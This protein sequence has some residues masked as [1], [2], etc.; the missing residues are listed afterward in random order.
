[1]IIK[2]KDKFILENA[3]NTSAT[4]IARQHPKYLYHH[5]RE[6]LKR[7]TTL[8]YLEYKNGKYTTTKVGLLLI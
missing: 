6:N 8:K 7:L 2:D 5:L 3:N 4:D 1:M